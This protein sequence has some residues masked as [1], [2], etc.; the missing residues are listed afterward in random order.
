MIG[1][2]GAGAGGG[3]AAWAAD[4]LEIATAT[5]AADD[6]DFL[7]PLIAQVATG[8]SPAHGLLRAWSSDP[9]PERLIALTRP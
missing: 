7:A 9:T 3:V 1:G 8:E 2:G 5:F 4:L 6:A